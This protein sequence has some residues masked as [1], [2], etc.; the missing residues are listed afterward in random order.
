MFHVEQIILAIMKNELKQAKKTITITLDERLIAA[1][2]KVNAKLHAQTPMG[3]STV[4]S[5][6][7]YAAKCELRNVFKQYGVKLEGE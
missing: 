3:E 5:I 7:T 6:I 2:E 1:V 4:T